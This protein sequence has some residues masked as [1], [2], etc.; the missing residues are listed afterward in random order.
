MPVGLINKLLMIFTS[1]LLFYAMPLI[2]NERAFFF[3]ENLESSDFFRDKKINGHQVLNIK[4]IYLKVSKDIKI[5]DLF[6][7]S[8]EN[9]IF[10]G[11]D[12]ITPINIS[13]YQRQLRH[14][15]R[16]L[17]SDAHIN[18]FGLCIQF[19]FTHKTLVQ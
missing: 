11:E 8:E 9:K 3:D 7:H 16:H 17:S 5:I 14:L 13:S 1:F 4:D 6:F 15:G 19:V 2:A 10:I 12:I 18:L